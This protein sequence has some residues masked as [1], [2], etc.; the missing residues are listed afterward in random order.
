[1]D[2]AS[3]AGAVASFIPG[4]GV[5]GGLVSTGADIA[6]DIEK[7][8]F[9]MS[10]IINWNTAANVGGVALGAIGLGGVKTLLKA[11]K[12]TDSVGDITKLA[13]KASKLN[14]S[15]AEKESIE[16]LHKLA[17]KQGTNS[18][19]ELTEK[20]ATLSANEQSVIKKGME[21]MQVVKSSSNPTWAGRRWGEI[22][23][24]KPNIS[25]KALGNVARTA[26]LIPAGMS[27]GQMVSD[28]TAA[29]GFNP[30]DIKLRDAKNLVYGAGALTNVFKNFRAVRAIKRQG[31]YTTTPDQTKFKLGDNEITLN[32]AIDMPGKPRSIFGKPIREGKYNASVAKTKGQMSQAMTKE[33]VT[34]SDADKKAFE[35]LDLSTVQSVKGSTTPTYKLG[36]FPKSATGDR[37]FDTRDYNIAKRYLPTTPAKGGSAVSAP[38]STTAP[39]ELPE[40]TRVPIEPAKPVTTKTAP[41]TPAAK[42]ETHAASRT[43][44]PKSKVQAAKAKAANK[45][46]NR[47]KISKHAGG[48]T[49][50]ETVITAPK[51]QTF[52]KPVAAA[53]PTTM[54]GSFSTTGT[55][56][57]P[58][59]WGGA[60]NLMKAF[61]PKLDETDLANTLMF[62]NTLST[63][64]KYGN[65]ARQAIT[66]GAYRLPGMARQYIRTDAPL[67]AQGQTEA[68]KLTSQAGRIARSTSDIDKALGVQLSGAAQASDV[69]GKYSIM[70]RERLDKLRAMQQDVNAKTAT[71]NTEVVGKNRAISA[72]AAKS[73]SLINANQALS[74]NTAL[75]NFITSY[76]Q[77]LKRKDYKLGQKELFG[78]YNAPEYKSAVEAY[79][80]AMSDA[81]KSK[82]YKDWEAQKAKS[83]FYTTPFEQSQYYKGFQSDV[84]R[85]KAALELINKP[86]QEMKSEQAFRQSMLFIKKGGSLSKEDRIEIE[87]FKAQ[88]KSQAKS[89]E[90]S[91]KAI[92]HNNEMLQKA[93][94]KVFK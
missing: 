63:N 86:L 33:G 26:S 19:K 73:L 11:A 36:E 21:A 24:L 49:L 56:N 83:S 32:A 9:Q 37:T 78:A 8:G 51:L 27:A 81:N 54:T 18:L 48:G 69:V 82:Y 45:A 65:L 12:L 29:G 57:K 34:L 62:A 90:L 59:L 30:E 10:D 22:K 4:L 92:L 41:K 84:E 31:L 77:N 64:A 38:A 50:P 35:E 85:T 53:K 25:S 94:I 55:V 79:K 76:A 44:A 5:I 72:D 14:L 68:A 1:M 93:L 74:Q 67:T 28:A 7:D 89:V 42:V 71:Y 91:F 88:N 87:R 17:Q 6:K 75:S 61:T 58:N 13:S 46:K 66:E 52:K 40:V 70:D 60:K 3:T 2:V 23:S 80:S 15:A 39:A 20:A 16:G 43:S 47:K